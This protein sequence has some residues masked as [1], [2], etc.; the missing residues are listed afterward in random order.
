MRFAACVVGLA[1]TAGVPGPPEVVEVAVLYLDQ[2]AIT[3]PPLLFCCQPAGPVTGLPTATVSHLSFAPPWAQVAE[4]VAEA[5][6]GRTVV[7]HDTDRLDILRRHLPDWQPDAVLHTRDLAEHLW[8]GLPGYDL[9]ALSV[10]LGSGHTTPGATGEADDVAHLL[11]ALTRHTAPDS[12]TPHGGWA[13]RTVG[14]PLSGPALPP[15]DRG[16]PVRSPLSNRT[17]RHTM[18]PSHPPGQH[19]GEAPGWA[20]QLPAWPPENG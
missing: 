16:L 8:P 13:P 18:S 19:R 1:T 11:L 3:R 7:T 4:R 10:V 17:E 15:L 12:A 9:H 5:L 14:A 6:A 20:Y 2:P